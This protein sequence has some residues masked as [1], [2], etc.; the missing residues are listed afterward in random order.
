[1]RLEER[2]FLS[3]EIIEELCWTFH[4]HLNRNQAV[5]NTMVFSLYLNFAINYFNRFNW[6][7]SLENT[8]V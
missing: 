4:L 2:R 3:L 8:A 5:L 7:V 1:M 6:N